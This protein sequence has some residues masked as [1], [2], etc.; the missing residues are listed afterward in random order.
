MNNNPFICDLGSLMDILARG[1]VAPETEDIPVIRRPN[2]NVGT[3]PG[4]KYPPI[5]RNLADEIAARKARIKQE[6]DA[7]AEMEKQYEIERNKIKYVADD[8]KIQMT[9]PREKV[10]KMIASLSKAIQDAPQANTYKI[11]INL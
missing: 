7:L 3:G 5:P 9:I 1:G 2:V 8:E 10:V 11:T 4:A 6:Q